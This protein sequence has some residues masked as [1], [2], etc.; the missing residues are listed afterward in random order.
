MKAVDQNG[1]ADDIDHIERNGGSDSLA[2][3]AHRAQN[4]GAGVAHGGEGI[5]Q[6][7][8]GKVGHG[9]IKNIC[10]NTAVDQM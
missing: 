4:R 3:F 9:I 6:K 2:V 1:I 7:G 10:F 5:A 8:N